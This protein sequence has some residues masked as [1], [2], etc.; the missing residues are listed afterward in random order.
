[1]LEFGVRR[2]HDRGGNAGTRAALIGGADFTSNAGI[3]HL[4]GYPPKGTTPIQW[5]KLFWRRA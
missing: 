1:M 3:S 5:C 2:A 4:L